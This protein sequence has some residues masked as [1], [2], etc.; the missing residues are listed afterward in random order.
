MTSCQKTLH[1][2]HVYHR[3]VVQTQDVRPLMVMHLALVCQIIS[4][5]HQIAV[6]NAQFIQIVLAAKHAF[7]TDVKIRAQARVVLMLNVTCITTFQ[8][9][10]V[11][12][13][14]L[15]MHLLSAIRFHK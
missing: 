3:R 9:A 15:A 12:M 1:K 4:V 10:H 6:Q 8:S 13:V 5:I 14:T 7:A 11:M 2:I